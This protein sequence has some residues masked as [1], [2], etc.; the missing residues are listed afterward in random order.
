MFFDPGSRVLL[1]TRPSFYVTRRSFVIR[2]A[3]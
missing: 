3:R 1:R 2:L